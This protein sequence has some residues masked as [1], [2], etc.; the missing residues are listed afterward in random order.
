M[1]FGTDYSDSD[2]YFLE[3]WCNCSIQ[4]GPKDEWMNEL[5][6]GLFANIMVYYLMSCDVN[7]CITDKVCTVLCL[8]TLKTLKQFVCSKWRFFLSTFLV[9]LPDDLGNHRTTLRP[10]F[11]SLRSCTTVYLALVS[12]V[13]LLLMMKRSLLYGTEGWTIQYNELP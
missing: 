6:N 9:H 8:A 5:M 4:E 11:Y 2:V 3:C 7:V 12:P 10:L 1:C 13:P